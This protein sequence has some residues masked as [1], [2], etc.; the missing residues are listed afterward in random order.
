MCGSS[1]IRLQ[2]KKTW[3][4]AKNHQAQTVGPRNES[5]VSMPDIEKPSE[6]HEEV[7][8]PGF[9]HGY[10]NA[11]IIGINSEGFSFPM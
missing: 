4:T 6:V 11:K 9:H 5:Q 7:K 1:E 2:K 3:L 10:K 8:K